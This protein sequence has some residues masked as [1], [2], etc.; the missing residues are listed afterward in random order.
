MGK[1]YK[2]NSELPLPR[3]WRRPDTMRWSSDII[4][5]AGLIATMVR[6]A[7]QRHYLQKEAIES[8]S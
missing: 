6:H 1:T 2:T 8:N 4:S 3:G 5:V 7:F